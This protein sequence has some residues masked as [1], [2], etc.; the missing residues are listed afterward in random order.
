MSSES[1]ASRF[2]EDE[3]TRPCTTCRMPVSILATRCRYCGTELG[4]PREETRSLSSQDLGGETV[5]HYAPSS[6]VMDALESF[7][8]EQA[9][10]QRKSK[11]GSDGPDMPELDARSR[12]LATAVRTGPSGPPRKV[13]QFSWGD[14]GRYAL[15]GVTAVVL[16]AVALTVYPRFTTGQATDDVFV[17]RAPSLIAMGAPPLEVLEAALEGVRNS[18]SEANLELLDRAREL[19]FQEVTGILETSPWTHRKLDEA[20][21]LANQALRHDPLMPDLEDLVAAE[22]NAYN[23]VLSSADVSSGE[24]KFRLGRNDHT[25]S[26]EELVMGRFEVV[27]IAGN[28]VRLR[29]QFRGGRELNWSVGGRPTPR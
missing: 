14:Y 6:N 19:V 23:A 28:S 2:R 21:R 1:D 17:N 5:K 27:R 15:G 12:A 10:Q 24:I 7:R 22:V 26:R 9:A 8:T 13:R 3:K 16:I 20:S 29:D 25:V 11:D 4:R 18:P